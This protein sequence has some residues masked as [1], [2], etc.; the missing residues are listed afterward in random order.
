MSSQQTIIQVNLINGRFRRSPAVRVVVCVVCSIYQKYCS[1]L[2]MLYQNILALIN[3]VFIRQPLIERRALASVNWKLV[4]ANGCTK[5][6]I[7]VMLQDARI[8]VKCLGQPDFDWISSRLLSIDNPGQCEEKRF[9]AMFL[10]FDTFLFSLYYFIFIFVRQSH[11]YLPFSCF[12]P[13]RSLSLLNR[14]TTLIF[15]CCLN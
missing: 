11:Q 14:S 1:S 15:S 7:E 12:Q 10:R 6:M 3:P 2:Y 13:E 9:G 8:I 5:E 4:T